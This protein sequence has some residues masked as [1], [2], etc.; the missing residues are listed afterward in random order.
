[1]S[2]SELL[3]SINALQDRSPVILGCRNHGVQLRLSPDGSGCLEAEL[4]PAHHPARGI[5]EKAM[6]SNGYMAYGDFDS[7]E[8]LETMLSTPD[9]IAWHRL[10]EV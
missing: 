4:K 9:A 2:L 10:T 7:I 5:H 6:S 1:M 8:E 3:T